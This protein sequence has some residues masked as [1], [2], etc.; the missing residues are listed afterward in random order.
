MNGKDKFDKKVL[1]DI[2]SF[3]DE[4]DR[5]SFAAEIFQLEFLSIIEDEMDKNDISK[6]ELADKLGV[7]ASFITQLFKA[8]KILNLKMLTK[9][10]NIFEIDYEFNPKSEFQERSE[11]VFTEEFDIK[12]NIFKAFGQYK[13]KNINKVTGKRFV[14]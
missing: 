10:I 6:K 12:G 13:E 8:N 5:E 7:T 11:L 4:K 1:I 2:L 3:K 14:A 9:L